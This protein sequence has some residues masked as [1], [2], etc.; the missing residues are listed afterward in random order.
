[1][2]SDRGKSV[3]PG[4]IIP[5][6]RTNVN[7]RPQAPSTTTTNRCA[8]FVSRQHTFSSQ[9]KFVQELADGYHGYRGADPDSWTKRS[10]KPPHAFRVHILVPEGIGPALKGFNLLDGTSGQC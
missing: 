7:R 8:I 9:L 1:M 10:D 6:H 4:G 2:G 3:K 5:M